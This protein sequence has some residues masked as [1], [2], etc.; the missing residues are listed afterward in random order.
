MT[1]PRPPQ[2]PTSWANRPARRPH[3]PTE[4]ARCSARAKS[5]GKQCGNLPMN[6]GHVCG[7]HGGKAP[8]VM[9][10]AR[11]RTDIAAVQAQAAGA[12][13]FESLSGV[14]DPLEALSLL[15]AETLAMKEALAARVNALNGLSYTAVGAGTEQLR[16]E[17]ALYERA[18]DRSAKFLEILAKS[19]FEERR[20]RI[21]ES[22][23]LQVA[24]CLRRI[25]ARLVLSEAQQVLVPT[26]V[27]EELRA[28][29]SGE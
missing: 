2:T 17:V 24:E 14:G 11:R 29:S 23:G 19:G 27:P 28:L 8:A 12:L 21:A 6:G 18:L 20:T 16:S 1:A 22:Q 4:K 25:F 15:T 7:V 9:A 3:G 13:A 26:V 10:A 5:T